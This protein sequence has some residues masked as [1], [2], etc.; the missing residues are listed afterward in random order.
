MFVI[1]IDYKI[2]LQI[3]YR[4]DKPKMNEKS[5]KNNDHNIELFF[6]FQ[7]CN[8]EKKTIQ[9]KDQFVKYEFLISYQKL[10]QFFIY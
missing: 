3:T 1:L 2:I 5:Q 7:I 10:Q 6:S 4:Y 9:I 8:S